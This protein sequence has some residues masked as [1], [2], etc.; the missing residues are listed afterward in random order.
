M[1]KGGARWGRWGSFGRT[2]AKI[3]LELDSIQFYNR[4]YSL[5]YPS[6]AR[7]YVFI[8]SNSYSHTSSHEPAYGLMYEDCTSE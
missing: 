6:I 7:V 1:E 4:N 8:I 3:S 5:E 2:D